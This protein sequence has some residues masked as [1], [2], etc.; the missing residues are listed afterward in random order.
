MISNTT[1]LTPAELVARYK[2]LGDIERGFRVLK[3]SLDL[4]PVHHRLPDRI[5]AHT[6]I[7]FLALVIHR[8]LR[9]RL[10]QASSPL[11]PERLLCRLKGIQLHRARL[12]SGKKL[13]GLTAMNAEQRALFTTIGVEVPTTKL[14]D[15]AS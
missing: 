7:C 1:S 10:R 2:E 11:S 12:A 13:A 15:A 14:V 3:S 4:A 9:F 5:R 8:V 6:L